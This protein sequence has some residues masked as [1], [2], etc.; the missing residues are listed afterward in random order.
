MIRSS[1]QPYID[2]IDAAACSEAYLS[3]KAPVQPTP[4][5]LFIANY[6]VLYTHSNVANQPF[7]FP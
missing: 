7:G 2:K 3:R 5:R 1:A 4:S 6:Y